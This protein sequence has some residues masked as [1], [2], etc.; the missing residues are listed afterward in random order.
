MLQSIREKTSGWIASIILGLVI[1]TMAFFGIESYLTTKVENFVAKVEGPAKFL[2]FG[3]QVREITPDEFRKRFDQIRQ[4]QRQAEGDKFDAAA[5][6]TIANKRVVLD[7]LIDEALLSIVAERDGIVLPKNAI[8][9]RIMSEKA[10]QIAGKFDVNQYQLALR[11]SN[12]TPKQF[13]ELVSHDLVQQFMPEQLA[14]SQVV[15]DAELDSLVRLSEQTRDIRFLDIPPP[16]LTA[17]PPTEA[18]LKKWYDTHTTQYRSPEKVAIEYVELNAAGMAVDTVSD[19][20]GLREKYEAAKSKYG[21]VE[22]RM[23]SHILVKVDEKATPAQVAAAQAKALELAAK[24]RAPGADFAALAKENSDDVGSKDVGG[25]LGPVEKGVFGDA[26]DKAFFALQPGQVSDPV[27]L[28]DGWHVLMFRELIPGTAKSFEE[29][30]PQLEAEYLESERERIYNDI[31]GRLVDKIYA[32][33][34]SLVPAAQELKLQVNRTGL[35]T[36]SA[37]EGIAALEPVR[38]AAFADTQ[39]IDRQVSDL[40][41]IEPNHTVVLHV[42][43]YQAAAPL[44]FAVVHDRVLADV[45][46]D[47]LVKASK[48]RADAL[49]ARATKG[50]TLDVLA[51]E[52]GRPVSDVP[53]ITRRA[54]NPQIAPLVDAAFQLPRPVAGKTQVALAKLAPD[55]YALVT[56]TAVKDGD[57][58]KLDA[59]TRERVKADIARSRGA[60]DARA[61][62]QNLRKQFTVKVAED[63]L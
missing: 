1:V 6:E 35:F 7:Q 59:A 44:P 21:A 24:A 5:F 14:V 30:R 63:R 2:T 42:T 40:V 28:P 61:Y 18:E 34:T 37:G 31:T 9:K 50:E 32:D 26:F 48:L 47:R 43:D 55:R 57:V 10:F 22:Q 20:T 46:K 38:K 39:K 58:S 12:M 52:V 29:V 51:T 60:V 53:A 15:G 62:I 16:A 41:E 56:V 4:Q 49:L 8:Q 23:A 11:G 25:D 3:K 27:R 33:P 36:R 17:P 54:P 13:E 45:M 19:E